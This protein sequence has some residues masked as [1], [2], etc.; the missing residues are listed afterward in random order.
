M[1]L[2][3]SV[4][5]HTHKHKVYID[6]DSK[7]TIA[8]ETL[9]SWLVCSNPYCCAPESSGDLFENCLTGPTQADLELRIFL[10][11]SPEC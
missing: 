1:Y 10:R 7:E 8:I 5:T 9:K 4:Y 2:Y 11:R 3:L 6:T